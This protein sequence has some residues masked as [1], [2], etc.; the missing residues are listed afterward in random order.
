MHYDGCYLEYESNVPLE[1]QNTNEQNIYSLRWL[2]KLKYTEVRSQQIHFTQS[3]SL[4]SNPIILNSYSIFT[5]TVHIPPSAAVQ[6][7]ISQESW[8]CGGSRLW[9]EVSLSTQA[10]QL[11]GAVY[12]Y[13]HY[14]YVEPQHAR[15]LKSQGRANNMMSP[16]KKAS[17]PPFYWPL[18]PNSEREVFLI[19]SMMKYAIE[20]YLYLYNSACAMIDK[21]FLSTDLHSSLC[22]ERCSFW[23]CALQ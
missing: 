12:E 14:Q 17:A 9:P 20:K 13:H 10:R 4:N 11:Q 19:R 3:P 16:R 5:V 6:Q 2:G 15:A 1:N 7:H 21:Y 18:L 8:V 22:S 23:H